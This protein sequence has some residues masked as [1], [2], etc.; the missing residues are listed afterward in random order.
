MNK[1]LSFI[2]LDNIEGWPEIYGEACSAL[3]RDP[4]GML[5]EA[6]DPIGAQLSAKVLIV[7]LGILD[8]V[9]EDEE[10]ANSL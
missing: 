4:T 9:L 1:T 6:W 8:A 5:P 3:R 10:E 2:R 7:G